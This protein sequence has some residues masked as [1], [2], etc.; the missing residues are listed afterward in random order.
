MNQELEKLSNKEV[1][2]LW[3]KTMSEARKQQGFRQ[4]EA[5]AQNDLGIAN[6]DYYFD[7]FGN[8]IEGKKPAPKTAGHYIDSAGYVC[9]LAPGQK[10][11][12][13]GSGDN[14]RDWLRTVDI[15]NDAEVREALG[16]ENLFF[17]TELELGN[18][19]IRLVG[20][21]ESD[22]WLVT[23][24]SPD[25][26]FDLKFRLAKTLICDEA[27][28]K[29]TAYITT[30]AGPQFRDLTDNERRMCE[31][32]AVGNR[33]N[34]LVSYIQCRLPEDL[35]DRFLQLGAAGDEQAIL[36]FASDEK[37]SEIVEEA[38]AN[39][40]YFANPR[41]TEDFFDYVRGNDGGRLWTFA[42]LDTLW[43]RYQLSNTLD[44]LAPQAA[45]TAEDLDQM[46][47]AEIEST[48]LAARKLRAGR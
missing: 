1:K 38:V 22:G 32:M 36:N 14:I 17:E 27:I 39:V 12:E 20:R 23:S 13:P 44:N 30:K 11:P 3:Q 5:Q 4:A 40:Y 8:V 15:A 31:R 46:S 34:A 41:C 10:P 2:E 19:V 37:I 42:L 47:D 26:V 21:L 45:P 43:Q 48:L 6:E 33:L 25:G 29:A 24:R 28:E 16:E 9:D 7:A 35:A 18:N